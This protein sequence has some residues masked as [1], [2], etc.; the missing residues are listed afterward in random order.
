MVSSGLVGRVFLVMRAMSQGFSWAMY[1]CNSAIGHKVVE[2][3]GL[4]RLVREGLPPPD[5]RESPGASVYVDNLA[6]WGG[7]RGAAGVH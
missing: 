3:V 2:V 1:F 6:T 7:K 5:L 4:D